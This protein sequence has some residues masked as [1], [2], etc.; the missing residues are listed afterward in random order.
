MSQSP[1]LLLVAGAT[2]TGKSALGIALAQAQGGEI[3]NADSQQFYRGLDIGTGKVPAAER[4]VPHWLLDVCEPGATMTAMSF[5]E[6]AQT[7]ITEMKGRSILP[8]IVGG[9]GLYLRALLEGLDPLPPRHPEIRERLN[10]EIKDKGSE[11][12]FL[13][14]KEIDLASAEKISPNDS[15]RLIRY[16]EIAEVTGKAPSEILKKGRAAKLNYRVQTH[17]IQVPR[18]EL[19][20]RIK[21]RVHEMMAQGWMEEVQG[22]MNKGHGPHHWENKPIGYL[23]LAKVCM[24]ELKLEDAIKNIILRT[25]QYAKRQ[26]IFFRGLF[27]NPAYQKSGSQIKVV[28]EGSKEPNAKDF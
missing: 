13:R 19:R 1:E 24:G 18:P 8:I 17:W 20:E 9:T 11:A 5:A 25:Q 26:E 28:T 7:R 4:V 3:L 21:T 27:K 23:D 16:L 10:A 6:Q 15:S 2:A 14:L 22:F 12:L